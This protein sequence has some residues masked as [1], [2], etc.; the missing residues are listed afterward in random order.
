MHFEG[1]SQI[2]NQAKQA[3]PWNILCA[4]GIRFNSDCGAR[5]TNRASLQEFRRKVSL[6][7]FFG[8]PT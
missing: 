1:D 2:L 4:I 5:R 8:A 7:E 3:S 6:A